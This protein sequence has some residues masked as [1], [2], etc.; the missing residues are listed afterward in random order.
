[1]PR[2]MMCGLASLNFSSRQYRTRY[3]GVYARLAS[4][5]FSEASGQKLRLTWVS[6][7]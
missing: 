1:M 2:V 4:T 6:Q 3:H 5:Q 7:P